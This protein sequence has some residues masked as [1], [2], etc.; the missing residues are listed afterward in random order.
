[1]R[2]KID[3][4]QRKKVTQ[5]NTYMYCCSYICLISKKLVDKIIAHPAAGQQK[6]QARGLKPHANGLK[7]HPTDGVDRPA[8]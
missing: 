2:A 6:E 1:M 7:P 3:P 5:T 8:G 4:T